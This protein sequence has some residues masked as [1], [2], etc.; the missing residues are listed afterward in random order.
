MIDTEAKKQTEKKIQKIFSELCQTENK[1]Y[2]NN[3]EYQKLVKQIFAPIWKWA[4]I[5]FSEE[6]VSNAGVEV[7]QC[8]KRTIVNYKENSETSYIAYL[9]SCLKNEIRHKKEKGEL[10]KFRICTRD[11]YSRAVDLI[12]TANRTGKNPN[13][14]KVQLWLARQ[15]GLTLAQ[16]K[17][18]IFKYYQSQIVEEQ[19]KNSETGKENSVFETDAVQNNYMTP[20]QNFF[21]TE[22]AIADLAKI[23]KAFGECQ[24]RQK[25]YLTSFV[26]LKILQVLERNFLIEQII[27]LLQER[28][29]IDLE[30]LQIFV[31]Q[32]AM[33]TQSDLAVKYE[34]DDGFI[35]NALKTFFKKVE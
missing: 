35:S 14:E 8:V 30:L 25:V 11:E 32:K 9:Y 3:I 20:E 15:S 17:D 21:K 31:S 24:E 7:F 16:A 13:N 18:L 2:D 34:K 6:D 5:C 29:F 27:E 4:I 19:I 23:E 33:P 12:N 26:T 10:K 28:N 1:D 22:Y